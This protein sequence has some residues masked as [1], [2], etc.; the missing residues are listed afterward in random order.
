[1]AVSGVHPPHCPHPGGRHTHTLK[2]FPFSLDKPPPTVYTLYMSYKKISDHQTKDGLAKG[3]AQW[4]IINDGKSMTRHGTEDQV[5]ALDKPKKEEEIIVSEENQEVNVY[6]ETQKVHTLS[7][8]DE[9]LGI[10]T[11]SPVTV[12]AIADLIERPIPS[13]RRTL[14][15]LSRTDSVFKTWDGLYSTAL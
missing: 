11:A 10:I 12:A 9:I 8:A 4:V 2:Y 5:K 6:Q 13:T 15:Q 14:N 1:M 7:V 3:L